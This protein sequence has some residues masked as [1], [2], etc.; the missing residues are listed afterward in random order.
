MRRTSFTTDPW[1][2]H[3]YPD[4]H[5]NVPSQ[6]SPT[7]VDGQQEAHPATP[8]RHDAVP[9]AHARRSLLGCCF[10]APATLEDNDPHDVEHGNGFHAP[11]EDVF[12]QG[13][14]EVPYSD[15]GGNPIFGDFSDHDFDSRDGGGPH[16][17]FGSE[18]DDFEQPARNPIFDS[19]SDCFSDSP[20]ANPFFA[21]GAAGN[22]WDD[23]ASTPGATADGS[24]PA[25][26]Q[27]SHQ[28]ANERADK[29]TKQGEQQ[30]HGAHADTTG[31]GGSFASSAF[32]WLG[33]GV[34]YLAAQ[35]LNATGAAVPDAEPAPEKIE[36][37]Y[38]GKP[39]AMRQ[40]SMLEWESLVERLRGHGVTI[41]AM[42]M[43][44]RDY[45]DY[46]LNGS[47]SAEDFNAKYAHLTTCAVENDAYRLQF[48]RLHQAF[49]KAAAVA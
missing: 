2:A 46:S 4:A 22:G 35:I 10:S 23:G 44:T 36:F 14:N 17:M 12:G 43:W 49:R 15:D 31:R 8:S 30:T 33:H 32:E 3:A 5:R 34:G 21:A 6:G 20:H 28:R 41:A 27:G 16:S 45:R 18:R 26:A 48:A 42:Q 29:G 7:S 24:S 13:R 40:R 1:S 11:Y 37:I 47:L 38:H 9:K 25:P 19:G 39:I